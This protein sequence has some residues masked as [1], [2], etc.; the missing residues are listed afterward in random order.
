MTSL[1]SN[2]R[3]V[4]SRFSSIP[5]PVPNRTAS[6]DTKPAEVSRVRQPSL[7]PHALRNNSKTP[8]SSTIPSST[9]LT[10]PTVINSTKSALRL[11]RPASSI[12][13]GGSDIRRS[14]PN[15]ITSETSITKKMQPD[16]SK[17]CL[18]SINEKKLDSTT[19]GSPTQNLG[20][21]GRRESPNSDSLHKEQSDNN[22]S[23]FN[24]PKSYVGTMA[25][26]RPLSGLRNLGNTCFMNS[27]LQCI[28][29]S[30]GFSEEI[31]K[32]TLAR[33]VNQYSKLRGDLAIKFSDLI[34]SMRTQAEVSPFEIKH[35]IGRLA[36]QFMGY[37]QQDSCEFF[38][39]LLDGLHHDLDRVRSKPRYQEML[40]E[41]KKGK[42][43]VALDW[44]E[45]SLSR[46]DSLITD[47]FQGQQVSTII[48]KKCGHETLSCDTFLD[49]ALALPDRSS[50][51]IQE[52]FD[53]YTAPSGVLESYKCENCKNIK[54]CTQQVGLWRFPKILAIQLK[55]F[56]TSSWSRQK[57]STEI[58]FPEALD[59]R[60]YTHN[61]EEVK[62]GVYK[63]YGVSHHMGS[64]ISGHYIA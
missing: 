57:L 28:S 51:T 42:A 35:L 43:K 32:T 15:D 49:L 7:G 12:M 29:H 17:S 13:K 41:A 40:G 1:Y 37:N 38:R 58:D 21:D 33:D 5:N 55:R 22:F 2:T 23:A 24:I 3:R 27:I 39:V 60:R 53:N 16:S 31:S 59:L 19:L 50:T 4:N 63:L 6:R 44:W 47:F 25:G 9:F 30:P 56:S 26:A 10:K 14:Q 20:R 64:L 54:C 8:Q 52:C 48:C 34:R 45:Y 46:D 61:K 36:P 62:F 11:T 18:P